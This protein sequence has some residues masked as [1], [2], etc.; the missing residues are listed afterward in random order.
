[1]PP[2]RSVM[3][4]PDTTAVK[5]SLVP[6]ARRWRLEGLSE[7][8]GGGRGER[9]SDERFRLRFLGEDER[10]T[11]SPSSTPRFIDREIRSGD[12]FATGAGGGLR[13]YSLLRKSECQ[14]RGLTFHSR[15]FPSHRTRIYQ[16]MAKG[17]RLNNP[18][19]WKCQFDGI[20][21]TAF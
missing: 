16:I 10:E 2:A 9:E 3:V 15:Q 20:L 4:S 6:D 17:D 13:I 21:S 18:T 7:L 11:E 19:S 12:V 5:S 14:D 8:L 1:M